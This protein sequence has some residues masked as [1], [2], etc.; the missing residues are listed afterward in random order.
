MRLYR[1]LLRLYP[2]SFRAEY[3]VDMT[4]VFARQLRDAD[5][6]AATAVLW[7]D[8]LREVLVDAVAIHWD[9]VRNFPK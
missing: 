6:L 9:V 4:A 2:A 3:G 1:A 7:L 5:G 8:T